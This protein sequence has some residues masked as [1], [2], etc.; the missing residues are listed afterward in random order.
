MQK[1]KEALLLLLLSLAF[2]LVIP[3]ALALP[4]IFENVARDIVSIGNLNWLGVAD[5]AVVIGVTRLLIW[6]FVF[7]IVFAVIS[8]TSGKEGKSLGFLQR[9]HAM[10]I[11]FVVATIAAIFLPAS[12]L[13]ATG[14]GWATAIA[15]ILIGGPIVGLAF[16]LWKIPPDGV[17]TRSTYFLKLVLCCL[18]FW[19]LTAMRYHLI[20]LGAGQ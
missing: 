10:V 14:V 19:I 20:V 18:L 11:A 8:A 9:N 12:V 6:I 1:R 7:T 5:S 4:S 16:L 13:A 17:N 2:L 15:L 3:S